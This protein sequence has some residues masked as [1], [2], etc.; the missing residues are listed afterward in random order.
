MESPQS[1]QSTPQ[2]PAKHGLTR[3]TRKKPRTFPEIFF[4]RKIRKL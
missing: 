4:E 1:P 2:K 3:K